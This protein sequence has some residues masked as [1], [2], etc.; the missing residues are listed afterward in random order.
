MNISLWLLKWE[1]KLASRTRDVRRGL[2]G[3][4]VSMQEK[5]NDL[6]APSRWLLQMAASIHFLPPNPFNPPGRIAQN[7]VSKSPITP[8]TRTDIFC[9]N[10][11]TTPMRKPRSS[12]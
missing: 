10:R 9:T 6:R 3:P 12:Q 8:T 2:Q 4:I 11:Y 7:C 1:R 5:A